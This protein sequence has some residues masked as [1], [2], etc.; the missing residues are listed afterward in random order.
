MYLLKI[1]QIW[2]IL[3]Q[4]LPQPLRLVTNT[5]DTTDNTPAALTFARVV[6][7][8]TLSKRAESIDPESPVWVKPPTSSAK[9]PRQNAPNKTKVPTLNSKRREYTY[10]SPNITAVRK[11][12][13]PSTA[14]EEYTT[15]FV[16]ARAIP[17]DVGTKSYP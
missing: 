17:S 12:S 6:K 3:Y 2:L 10:T 13:N 15:V 8:A 1:E 14:N 16:V 4:Q 5:N 7:P 9:K 11:K